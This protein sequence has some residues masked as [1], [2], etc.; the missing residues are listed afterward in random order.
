MPQAIKV[1]GT[2]RLIWVVCIAFVLAAAIQAIFIAFILQN[3]DKT[4]K[5]A[6]KE[7]AIL[8]ASEALSELANQLR[9]HRRA[10]DE[11]RLDRKNPESKALIKNSL[12]QLQRALA[13]YRKT[14]QLAALD[15]KLAQEIGDATELCVKYSAEMFVPGKSEGM[16]KLA[17]LSY[18]EASS[19]LY[20][21]SFTVLEKLKES[22]D[23]S[24]HAREAEDANLIFFICITGALIA[25]LVVRAVDRG[26]ANPLVLLANQCQKLKINEIIPAPARASNEIGLLQESFHRMSL[27]LAENEKSRR[28]FISLF[29]EMQARIISGVK[30]LVEELLMQLDPAL[31]PRLSKILSNLDGMLYL[32]DTMSDGLTFNLEAELINL[33]TTKLQTTE[34]IELSTAAVQSLIDK[35]HLVLE[36]IDDNFEL[37]GDRRLLARLIMN[38]LSNAAKFSAKGGKIILK[39][40]KRP[41]SLFCSVEDSGKGISDEEQ[42]KLFQKFSQLDSDQKRAG[43]GLGLLICKRITDAHGGSIGCRTSSGNGSCFYFEIPLEQEQI[44][45]VVNNDSSKQASRPEIRVPRSETSGSE[46]PVSASE[47]QV[48]RLEAQL[49]SESRVGN[50]S[51]KTGFFLGLAAFITLQIAASIGLDFKLKQAAAKS[52]S[53][54]AQKTLVLETQ[55]LLALFLTWRQKSG[56]AADARDIQAL[57][58]LYPLLEEQVLKAKSFAD[59]SRKISNPELV[60]LADSV[61]KQIRALQ[62]LG[63]APL[64]NGITDMALAARLIQIADRIGRRVEDELFQSL[65]IECSLLDKSYDLQSSLREEITQLLQ[66]LS[67]ASIF[68]LAYLLFHTGSIIKR[69]AVLNTKLDKIAAGSVPEPSIKRNDEIASLDKTLCQVAFD[70]DQADKHRQ[71]LMSL[72]NHDLRNPL[73]S[74]LFGI[75]IIASSAELTELQ[76]DELSSAEQEL[77]ALTRQVNDILELEK[78]ESKQFAVDSAVLALNEALEEMIPKIMKELKFTNYTLLLQDEE[79]IYIEA[80]LF[81]LEKIFWALI[82][83]AVKASAVN[84]NANKDIEIKLSASYR[85]AI[86]EIKDSGRGIDPVLLA[87]IFERNRTLNGQVIT[88]LGLPLASR[89]MSLL[90]GELSLNSKPGQGVTATLQFP[91]KTI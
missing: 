45:S 86:V 69:V 41:A 36:I 59:K 31:R 9:K 2:S 21:D 73:C 91:L 29:R 53:Y 7:F 65:S 6:S 44:I 72:V 42:A 18:L 10:V 63:K 16:H 23:K 30:S 68:I 87:R 12:L 35:K 19:K 40:E 38:L 37:Q 49:S 22:I 61:Y 15:P 85:K 4:E 27:N 78:I 13:F 82:S 51:I 84:A 81:C 52:S 88:G 74:V 58:A 5:S 11:A 71:E 75:E 64:E 28:A 26:I 77:R 90:G 76:R 33:R 83:N 25:V 3:I 46:I 89:Y 24:P 50:K 60:K 48:S 14:C 79:D 39:L 55:D 62:K 43:S 20:Q 34:L 1:P 57:Q 67:L 17:H 47:T 80:E 32:L 56:E 54:A 8:R 70:L 66:L